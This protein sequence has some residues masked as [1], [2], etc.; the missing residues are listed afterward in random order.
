MSNHDEL[1]ATLEYIEQ[2]RGISKEQLIRAVEKA[3]LSASRKSIRPASDLS[4]KM[5]PR[6]GEI[7]VW[8]KLKVVEAFA[9]NDEINL[10]EVAAKRPDAV[11]GDIIDWEVTPRDFGRIAASTARQAIIQEIKR[12]EKETVNDEFKDLEGEIVNG[13]VRRI[14][15]GDILVD[16]QKAEGVIRVK[17]RI[18]TEQYSPGD[19]INAL[20][21]KIDRENFGPS[22]ILSRSCP[23]FLRKLFEREVTEI[24]DKVVEIKAIARD[25]GSRSKVA[26][27]STDPRVDPVG[28]CV[29][30]RGMRVKNITNE[31][32]GERMDIIRYS[33]DMN[34]YIRNVMHPAKLLDVDYDETGKQMKIYVDPENSRLAFGRKGQNVKLA[35]KLIDCRIEIVTIDPN[36]EFDAKKA[37]AVSDLAAALSIDEAA[38]GVLVNKGYLSIDDLRADIDNVLAVQELDAAALQQIRSALGI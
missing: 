29:G 25:P 16:C 23:A 2:E 35:Q 34:E 7:K 32:S 13:N 21:V 20:L 17:D 4:I 31:L 24:H 26:V 1:L 8:A 3:L 5:N 14:D 30:M 22:L 9:G 18:P 15:S 12:A 27:T 38:A 19:R 37:Q 28:A 33:D 6:T 10:S 36:A 11:V